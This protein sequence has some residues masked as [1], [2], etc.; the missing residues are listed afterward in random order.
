MK[1]CALY[2]RVSTPEHHV[3]NQLCDLR[4]FAEQRGFEI[5]AEFIDAAVSGAK[6]RRPGLM[7]S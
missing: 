3:E 1:K 6:P 2:T 7:S 4:R 5:V